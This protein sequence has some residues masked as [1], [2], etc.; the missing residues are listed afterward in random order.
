MKKHQK[1][2][3]RRML[4]LKRETIVHITDGLLRNAVGGG[5]DTSTLPISQCV[6]QCPNA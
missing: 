4:E 1:N 3:S 2:Q 6:T 5:G